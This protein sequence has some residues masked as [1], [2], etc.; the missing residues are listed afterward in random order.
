MQEMHTALMALTSYETNDI[1]ANS[2]KN[3]LEAGPRVQKRFDPTTWGRKRNLL[4]KI[5]S[6]GQCSL[7]E[8]QAGMEHWGV[9]RV[10]LPE[11]Q[12]G[13]VGRRDQACGLDPLVPE[14]LQKHLNLNLKRLRAFEDA[15]LEVATYVEAKFCLRTRDSKTSDTSSRGHSDLMDVYVVNSLSIVMQGKCSSS[16]RDGWFKCGDVHFNEIAMHSRAQASNRIAKANR[17]SNGLRVSLDT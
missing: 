3:P 10:S 15:R 14:E 13:Q 6:P 5:V 4:R 1:V 2:S 11:E 12:E 16:E 8:L 7:M 17:A 9:L